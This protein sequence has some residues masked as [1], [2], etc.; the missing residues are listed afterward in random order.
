MA[1]AEKRLMIAVSGKGGVGKTTITALIVKILSEAKGRSI[2]VIDANP[3]SNLPDVLGIKVD[4]TVG[5]A[6]DDL[7]KAIEKAEIPRE[8]TKEGILEYEIFKILKETPNFDLLVMGRGEGE[9]CYCPVN[10]FLTRII[11]T[12]SK[13]YDL[14]LMDTA[15]G[16]EHLS[17]RTDRD[18]DVM[19]IVTDPSFMGLQTAKRIKE[20]AKEVHIAFK[21]IYLV[22]NRFNPE[23]EAFL[24]EEAEKIGIEYAGTVPTDENIFKFNLTGKPVL[25]LPPESPA[26]LAVKE[27]LVHMDLLG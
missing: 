13:N 1:A 10:A 21:K 25:S 3:D 27:I 20:I 17:R 23:M 2:L 4:K 16:L 11:D 7:K 14:T 8:M 26:L 22:G 6:T 9:G 19:I 15:A 18:V 24:K 12:L 5:M